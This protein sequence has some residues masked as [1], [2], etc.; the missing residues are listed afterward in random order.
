MSGPRT[1]AE[2]ARELEQI[3]RE[4]LNRIDPEITGEFRK[5][6]LHQV[7]LLEGC[8]LAQEKLRRRGGP[9]HPRQEQFWTSVVDGCVT[10]DG[11]RYYDA[12][13]EPHSGKA[14]LVTRRDWENAFAVSERWDAADFLCVLTREA[15]RV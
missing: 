2:I 13:L 5:D 10:I 11:H 14:V 12:A 7:G 4:A 8:L 3:T 9:E 15:S 6:V 1:D